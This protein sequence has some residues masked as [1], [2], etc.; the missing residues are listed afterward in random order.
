M[1]HDDPVGVTTDGVV[2]SGRSPGANG[3]A[4]QPLMDIPAVRARAPGNVWPCRG[5]T[6]ATTDG[7]L[8]V[9][10]GASGSSSA[11]RTYSATVSGTSAAFG[12]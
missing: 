8:V 10:P 6:P 7:R 2:A 5:V 4:R 3:Q 1:N 12:K 9:R 11:P